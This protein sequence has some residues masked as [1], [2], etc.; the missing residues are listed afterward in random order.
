MLR[1]AAR[2]EERSAAHR[3]DFSAGRPL[4]DRCHLRVYEGVNVAAFR[5]RFLGIAVML[6]P[7][8]DQYICSTLAQ[9]L[10]MHVRK[11]TLK[12]TTRALV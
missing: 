3:C 12:N 10:V 6:G 7:I 4:V 2:R 8:E 5:V 9:K 1:E 11:H